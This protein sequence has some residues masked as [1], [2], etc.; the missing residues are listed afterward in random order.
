MSHGIWLRHL[1]CNHSPRTLTSYGLYSSRGLPEGQGLHL[2][3]KSPGRALIP[4]TEEHMTK[5]GQMGGGF[6]T[7]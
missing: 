6:M 3:D 7:R 2:F 5:E 1:S 4:V